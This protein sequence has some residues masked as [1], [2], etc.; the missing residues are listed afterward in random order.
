MSACK[1]QTALV[2]F[3]RGN[4]QHPSTKHVQEAGQQELRLSSR[5]LLLHTQGTSQSVAGGCESEDLT[6][7]GSKEQIGGPQHSLT[8]AGLLSLAGRQKFA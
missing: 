2:G 5:H 4:R 6:P 8:E 7:E 3:G 1:T